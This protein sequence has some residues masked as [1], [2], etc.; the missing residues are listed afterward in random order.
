MEWRPDCPLVESNEGLDLFQ[1]KFRAGNRWGFELTSNKDS[2]QSFYMVKLHKGFIGNVTVKCNDIYSMT[3][4]RT[5]G[6][7]NDRTHFSHE[8]D[9]VRLGLKKTIRSRDKENLGGSFISVG[10]FPMYRFVMVS[11]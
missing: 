4:L 3:N 5:S 6:N 2:S 10:S 7:K 1:F 8:S 11:L 9:H